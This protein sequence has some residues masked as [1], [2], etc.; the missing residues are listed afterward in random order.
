MKRLLLSLAALLCV[1]ASRPAWAATGDVVVPA[2]FVQAI[3]DGPDDSPVGRTMILNASKS[4]SSGDPVKYAWYVGGSDASISE[5][6]DAIYTPEKP[7]LL[8]FRLVMTLTRDGQEIKSEAVHRVIAY[9]RKIVMIVDPSVP[10]ETVQYQVRTADEA[11][12]YLKVLRLPQP[13]LAQQ[14][15]DVLRAL[16]S[17]ND[18]A[19]RNADSI[20]L[21]TEGIPALQALMEAFKNNTDRLK[22]T[23]TQTIVLITEHNLHTLARAASGPFS[24][25]QP[26]RIILTRVEALGSFLLSPS[27]EAFLTTAKARGIDHRV[28]D[29]T[30]VT[31]RPWNVLSWLVNSMLIQGVSSQ[32]I[33]LLLMLPVIATIL[34]FLRQVVGVTTFGLFAPSIVALSFLAL[35]VQV[36]LLFLVF[37]VAT[38]YLTRAAMQ[39]FRLLYIPKVAIIL[40]A[41]S[42]TLLI[43]LSIGAAFRII[44]SPD[45]IFILLILSTLGESFLTAKTEKGFRGA[46]ISVGQTI[47]S[48]LLCVLIVRWPSFQSLIL[49]YPELVLLTLLINIVLG[50]WTGLRIVE[51]FRF[52]ELFR[53][54]QEE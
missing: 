30:T 23:H 22:E 9:R 18:A 44:L 51:Y 17:Q 46:V 10:D 26:K 2:P 12:T 47:L 1:L 5:E 48:A 43:L 25:L 39:R 19:F 6:V 52:R 13:A 33:V 37:I 42:I 45:S 31:I 7:G 4:L 41:V 34:A 50:R 16:V 49:A 15:D 20:I 40:T 21:W 24:V 36:G 53:H 3:I 14:A 28:L 54:L 32:S 11:G 27:S 8:D 29:A 38:G 35:G